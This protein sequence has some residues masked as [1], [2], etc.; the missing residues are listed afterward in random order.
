MTQMDEALK[1]SQAMN[2]LLLEMAKSQKES[3]KATVRIFMV[4][5]ICYTIL[6]ITLIVGF[7][8]YESQFEYV[9]EIVTEET[10]TQEVSGEGSEIN[11]VEGNLYKDNSIHNEGE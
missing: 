3:N 11:N 9:E 8:W 1:Q 7:F 4:S 2:Q 6:L 10:I 5:M